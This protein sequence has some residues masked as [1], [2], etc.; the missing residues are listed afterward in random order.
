MLIKDWWIE[1]QKN[2]KV[3]G[4]LNNA[5]ACRPDYSLAYGWKFYGFF[6]NETDLTQVTCKRC[7]KILENK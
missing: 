6:H 7:R 4:V 2:R 1:K 5:I 3:H